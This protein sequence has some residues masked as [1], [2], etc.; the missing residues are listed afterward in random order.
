MSSKLAFPGWVMGQVLLPEQFQAQQEVISAQ[1]ALRAELTGLPAYGLARLALDETLLATGALRIERL[2]YAFASGLLVDVPGNAILTNANLASADLD[3]LETNRTTLYLHVRNEV[4]DA[5]DLTRYEDDPRS[6]RRVIYQVELSLAAQL[7]D[8]RES[9]KL[10]E[11]A[12]KD[13]R[14]CLASYSPPLLRT[15]T[16]ASPFLREVVAACQQTVWAVEAQLAR[17]IKDAFLGREQVAELRRVR[18]AAHRVLAL[19]GD[20]GVGEEPSSVVALHPYLVFSSLRDF[21]LEAATLQERNFA[22][23]R[24]RHDALAECFEL[25]RRGLESTLGSDSL[26]TNRLEFER[27]ESWYVAGP[28]PE[29]LREAKEVFLIVKANSQPGVD[30]VKSRDSVSL[31]GVKLASPRRVDEVYTRALAGVPLRTMSAASSASFA[32]IYGHDAV[33]YAIETDDPEWRLALRDEGICFPAWRDLE[34]VS[35]VLVWGG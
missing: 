2:T 5:S 20:H 4:T 7:D 1:L 31:E 13:E 30:S 15:G 24:Y 12:R 9:V 16:R 6:V 19:L 23:I 11:L 18:A 29:G 34:A 33:Y 28:F 22:A 35:A 21:Y 26:S 27:R 14:W 32:Q 17:R 3:A 25:L 10:L 8:A